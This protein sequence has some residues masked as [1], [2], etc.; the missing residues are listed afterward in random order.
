MF[1]KTVSGEWYVIF[2]FLYL[3]LAVSFYSLTGFA[4]RTNGSDPKY[5]LGVPTPAQIK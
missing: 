2:R 5:S 3:R 4:R 1:A